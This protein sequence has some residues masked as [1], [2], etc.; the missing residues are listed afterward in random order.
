[1]KKMP[2]AAVPA[3]IPTRNMFSALADNIGAEGQASTVQMTLGELAV[4]R[5]S[6]PRRG[7]RALLVISSFRPNR[8]RSPLRRLLRE[9][10]RRRTHLHRLPPEDARQPPSQPRLQPLSLLLLR[11]L[12][13]VPPPLPVGRYHYLVWHMLPLDCLKVGVFD[14]TWKPG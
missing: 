2:T 4:L 7:K 10:A 5:P 8:H 3:P 12:S 6:R 1:M 14:R 13:L 9:H 11:P